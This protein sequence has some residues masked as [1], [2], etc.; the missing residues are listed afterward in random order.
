MQPVYHDTMSVGPMISLAESQS[1][2]NKKGKISNQ[3]M[4]DSRMTSKDP[5][6]VP[7]K[8]DATSKE[9]W[10]RMTKDEINERPLRKYQGPIHVVKN[11]MQA[12]EA[13]RLLEK[14]SLLGFDTETRPSFRAGQSYLPSVLQL[15]GADAVCVFQLRHCRLH[16]ALCGLLSNP[17]IV[18]AGVALDY[19]VKELNRLAPFKAAG[20]VDVGEWAKEAGCMNHGLRGLAALLLGFRVSKKAQTSN[21]SQKT[22]TWAQIEYAATDAWV[23]REL[24]G[25]LAQLRSGS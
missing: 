10:P 21:W 14:E 18:K 1:G 5:S 16:K 8:P 22:L 24:Y 15:A 13:V 25:R 17:S 7:N 23:G 3:H 20:F 11:A 6:E 2:A 12:E 9:T 4:T 19:D